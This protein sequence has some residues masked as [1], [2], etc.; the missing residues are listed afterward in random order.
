[1]KENFLHFLW[2][3]GL[4]EK[5]NIC[6]TKGEPLEIISAGQ[7]NTNAGPDFFNAKIKIGDTTWAGNVEVHRAASDWEKHAHSQ[8]KAYD[9]VILHVVTVD[10]KA[11]F[12]SSGDSLATFILR[13]DKKIEQR[14]QELL[15]SVTWI[16]CQAHI[17][18]V[19]LFRV[20]HF[21]GRILVE[22]ME[23]RNSQIS[24]ILNNTHNNWQEV[25]YQRLFR[26]FGFGTNALPF[27][28]LAKATP[29]QAIA[30]QRYSLMQV[31][32][33][34]FGQAGF[35]QEETLDSYQSELQNEYRFLQAKYALQPIAGHL[36]KFLRIRP[37]NFPT[38]RIAQLAKLLYSSEGFVDKLLASRTAEELYKLF[39]VQASSYWD[40]HYTFGKTSVKKPKLVGESS[41][42]GLV[43]NAVIPFLFAYG[44]YHHNNTM[45]E[46][47]LNILEALP[48]EKNNIIAGWHNIGI[49]PDNAFYAQALMQLKTAYCDE[50]RCLSCAIGTTQL[51]NV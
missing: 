20:K 40:E 48:P 1:M 34:L 51:A 41:V 32:A 10:D 31:E 2:K 33:L 19:A 26:A 50:K 18:N 12:R 17:G 14:Y 7:H 8:N 11:V 13:Y 38:V 5:E 22:R 45:C 37:D 30:K 49:K 24:G 46:T 42:Q 3:F 15:A 35:L 6:T 39:A 36:W 9:N 44:H 27:E 23:E 47:A 4:F 21:L 28:L 16:P 29:F 25:F 43:M